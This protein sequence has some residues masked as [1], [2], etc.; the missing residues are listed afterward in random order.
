M[1]DVYLLRDAVVR[2]ERRVIEQHLD[3]FEI[4]GVPVD[5]DYVFAS[6]CLNKH[7]K[8]AEQLVKRLQPSKA[9]IP[10]L[11]ERVCEV[12]YLE[13]AKWLA[14]Y[15]H[16]T[17]EDARRNDNHVLLQACTD[18]ELGVAKWLTEYFQLTT[19][20]ARADDNFALRRACEHKHFELAVWLADYFQLTSEDARVNNNYALRWACYNGDLNMVKWLVERF[21]L[22][23]E[24]AAEAKRTAHRKGHRNVVRWLNSCFPP[25]R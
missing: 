9:N 16:L 7:L 4:R 3:L 21:N 25:L 22:E 2:G 19:E 24:D 23:R 10:H 5:Y 6:L 12:S 17:I 14:D 20:D 13:T 15:F 11:F 18:G 8:V 1:N